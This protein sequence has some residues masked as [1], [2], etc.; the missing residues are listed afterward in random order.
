MCNDV[1]YYLFYK[2]SARSYFDFILR[3][4]IENPK[5]HFNPVL[6]LRGKQRNSSNFAL[7]LIKRID[8]DTSKQVHNKETAHNN[9][10][11]VKS[12]PSLVI[13]IP[14]LLIYSH[15]INSSM[16]HRHPPFRCRKHK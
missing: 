2:I 15:R 10:K 8:N 1:K 16:H 5:L 4:R 11:Y 9:K 3:L 12:N 14:R 13:L 7:F 6:L